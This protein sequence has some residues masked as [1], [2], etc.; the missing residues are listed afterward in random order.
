MKMKST[1]HKT[2]G[3]ASDSDRAR[4]IMK[5]TWVT[6]TCPS[7]EQSRDGFTVV[8]TVRVPRSTLLHRDTLQICI[9]ISTLMCT[10]VGSIHFPTPN[11]TQEKNMERGIIMVEVDHVEKAIYPWEKGCC[12]IIHHW[13][14]VLLKSWCITKYI[15]GVLMFLGG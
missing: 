14:V 1:V 3:S 2:H 7:S 11:W 10:Q 4:F 12:N 8:C 6:L 9:Y 15:I 13:K 5:R